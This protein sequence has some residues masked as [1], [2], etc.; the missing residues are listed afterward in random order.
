MMY[1]YMIGKRAK[2][3]NKKKAGQM[4]EYRFPEPERLR[5]RRERVS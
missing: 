2:G 4:L 1:S 5:L 3:K